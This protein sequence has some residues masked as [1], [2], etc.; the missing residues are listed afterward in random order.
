MQPFVMYAALPHG[1]AHHIQT[2]IPEI[3]QR[4]VFPRSPELTRLE[5]DGKLVRPKFPAQ[6][7]MHCFSPFGNTV[8][9]N[10]ILHP[11]PRPVAAE[12]RIRMQLKRWLR[13]MCAATRVDI[14]IWAVQM[15]EG[16]N[17]PRP[18]WE[19]IEDR[20]VELLPKLKRS[21]IQLVGVEGVQLPASSTFGL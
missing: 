8:N 14:S 16:Q 4:P 5:N 1:F 15:R 9:M 10:L 11:M 17:I 18:Q 13:I 20:F 3:P 19:R 12:Q 7:L 2:S 6:R 21:A